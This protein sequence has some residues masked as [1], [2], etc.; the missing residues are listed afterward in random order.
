[1]SE[2]ERRVKSVR[3]RA[4]FRGQGFTN[5]DLAAYLNGLDL[6]DFMGVAA[7]DTLPLD[8]LNCHSHFT[9]ICNLS[10]LRAVGTHFVTLV[11]RPTEIW[12]VDSLAYPIYTSAVLHRCLRELNRPVKTL[13]GAEDRIQSMDSHFCGGYAALACSV[14]DTNYK[15]LPLTPFLTAGEVC[16]SQD[17]EEK[18]AW[19]DQ[20]C[21]R[22]L[23]LVRSHLARVPGRKG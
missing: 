1:M 21:C 13:L 4:L 2:L 14:Y 12:Y 17:V 3:Q 20:V 19:N 22:N 6:R 5:V 11:G 18:L 9:L 10:V 16:K 8:L 15:P 7:A 23:S